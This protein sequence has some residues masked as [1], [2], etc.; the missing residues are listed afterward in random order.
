MS[1]IFDLAIIGGGPAGLT[2]YL[3]AARARLNIILVEKTS[4]GGQVLIT[5]FVENYPGFPDGISGFE[6]IE[7][8]VTQVKKLGFE[9]LREEVIRLEDLG[10]NKKLI[11]ASGNELLAQTVIIATGAK[12]NTLGVPGEKKLTGRGVSYCAT[13]DGPFFRDQVVAVVGGGNTAVQEAIFLTRF[14]SKVYLIHRRDQLRAQKILQER[15]LS[16]KKIIPIWNTVVEEILGDDQ[17]KAIKLKNCKTG[18]E[19]SLEVDGVFIFIGIT[20]NSDFVKDL[21]TLDEKGFIITDSEMRTNVPGIF[22]AGDVRSKSCRQIVTACGD[23]AT[24]AFLAEHF[25]AEK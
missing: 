13:C 11:L 6:L 14:A 2:A 4:P 21:L 24:A 1:D 20:P 25:L 17:V 23:G 3:Y 16:N 10:Q 8:F 12:P 7:S 22:A 18:E 5:D 9:P 15:A 19:S